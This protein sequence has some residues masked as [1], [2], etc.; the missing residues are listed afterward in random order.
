MIASDGD[1]LRQ[2]NMSKRMLMDVSASMLIRGEK[3]LDLLQCLI[4]YNIW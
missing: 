2:V 1:R 4:L 3:S